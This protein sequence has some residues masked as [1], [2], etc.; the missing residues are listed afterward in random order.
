MDE[1]LMLAWCVRQVQCWRKRWMGS[2]THS[3]QGSWRRSMWSSTCR[4]PR[5]RELLLT[6]LFPTTMYSLKPAALAIAPA[7]SRV[8]VCS[9]IA[10]ISPFFLRIFCVRVWLERSILSSYPG[11]HTGLGD[12]GHWGRSGRRRGS[13][14]WPW[15][16]KNTKL[17][18]MVLFIYLFFCSFTCAAGFWFSGLVAE[19]WSFAVE[20]APDK[21]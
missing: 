9:C 20:G 10:S 1:L 19:S 13:N 8:T 4:V 12:V 5:G 17:Y 18:L 16:R 14:L 15:V 6:L 3:S 2:L 11:W 21:F 7:I